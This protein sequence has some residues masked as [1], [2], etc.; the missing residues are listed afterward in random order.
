MRMDN[1]IELYDGSMV[2]RFQIMDTFGVDDKDY[3]VLKSEDSKDLYLLEMRY[4]DDEVEFLTI[5]DDDEFEEILELY[6]EL[7]EDS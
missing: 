2:K 7:K 4:T 1:T 6:E 3:A 5:D